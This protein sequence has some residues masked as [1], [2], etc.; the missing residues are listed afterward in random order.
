HG[1]HHRLLIP[2]QRAGDR[3]RAGGSHLVRLRVLV[4]VRVARN[5]RLLARV[6]E[7][8]GLHRGVP[9]HIHL[10]GVRA[11]GVDAGGASLVRQDQPVHDRGGRDARAVGR[12]AG[13]QLG[14]GR[15]RVVARDPG[16]IRAAS[17]SAL[18]SRGR[19]MS[20]TE[21]EQ[22]IERFYEAFDRRDG[23]AMAACYA[24][25]IR[26]SDPVFPGLQNDEPGAMWRMLTG[27]S[28]DLRVELL[29]HDADETSGTARWKATYTFTQT[30]RNVV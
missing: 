3:R 5:D 15:R 19:A 14:M 12:R 23:D 16:D 25:Q 26:F 10:V 1:P 21:N 18:P 30:G 2:R 4:G 22:L 8:P 28:D 9:A 7:L 29:E 13:P 24:P 27:R 11:G 20:A 6:R 17:R